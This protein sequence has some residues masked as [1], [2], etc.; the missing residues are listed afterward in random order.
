MNPHRSIRDAYELSVERLAIDRPHYLSATFHDIDHFGE[1]IAPNGFQITQLSRGVFQGKI[2]S[3]IAN[4]ELT[5]N[6]YKINQSIQALG[7]K[8]P[9][10]LIFAVL[11]NQPSPPAFSHDKLLVEHAIFGFDMQR[12]AHLIT[13]PEGQDQCHIEVSRTLFEHYAALANR[14]DL[15]DA[16][17]HRNMVVSRADRCSGLRD[18]LRQLFQAETDPAWYCSP[19]AATLLA[20]DL[21]PLLI[22]A[23]LPAH[24]AEAP[25]P[26]RRA[27]LV[28]EAKAYIMANLDQPLTLADICAAM[29]VSRR[30]LQYGFQEMLGM[31]PMAFVKI[32]RL[33]GIRRALLHGD[34][35]LGTVAHIAYKWGFFSLGHF[36]KH[37]KQLFGESPSQTL[38]RR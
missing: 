22:D 36:S 2:S 3:W 32:Q 6:R 19:H 16:F 1:A 9:S 35:K 30:S 12:P 31:G 14:Y 10:R 25:R 13:S 4:P 38:K 33:H 7:Y 11:L 15:D 8:H 24:Q 18:Y 20:Q 26:Y 21:M 23:L 5:I 28:S 37:Y 29:S 27:A 34:P 17:L